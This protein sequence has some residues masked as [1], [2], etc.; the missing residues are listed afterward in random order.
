MTARSLTIRTPWTERSH[1]LR[2]DPKGIDRIARLVRECR[3]ESQR[4]FAERAGVCA[5]T[6]SRLERGRT[7]SPHFRTVVD[8]LNALGFDVTSHARGV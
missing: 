2:T 7:R 3:N 5:G 8:I 4:A 1:R 6:V